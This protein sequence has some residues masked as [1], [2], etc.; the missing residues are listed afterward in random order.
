MSGAME[1]VE[2]ELGLLLRRARAAASSVASQV[3]P[4]LEPAAYPLLLR[5]AQVPGVRAADLAAYVGVGKATISRQLRRLEDLG[6]I[7][8]TPDPQDSRGHLISLSPEGA[9]QVQAARDGR[10]R[11]LN[12]ALSTWTPEELE[13]LASSLAHLNVTIEQARRVSPA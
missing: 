3:H 6:L 11:W 1:Q 5:A 13:T 12:N 8:R 7:T 10:R 2:R 4:D 9:R